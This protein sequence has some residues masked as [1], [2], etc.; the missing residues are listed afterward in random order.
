MYFLVKLPNEQNDWYLYFEGLNYLNCPPGSVV[1]RLPL[2]CLELV[3]VYIGIA[4]NYL[5][6][7][8]KVNNNMHLPFQ[9]DF[10]K[11]L[12]VHFEV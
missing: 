10:S 5:K 8:S 9:V 11:C 1:V 3:I 4:V 2:K 12:K 6:L 7:T